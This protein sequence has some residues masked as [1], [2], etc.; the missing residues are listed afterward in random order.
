MKIIMCIFLLLIIIVFICVIETKKENYSGFR[1][2]GRKNK[3]YCKD[4]YLNLYKECI[5]ASG[6][7]DINGDCF[8]RIQPYLISCYFTDF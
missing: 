5:K 2:V 6:G 8:N 3:N 1:A 4:Y 7:R